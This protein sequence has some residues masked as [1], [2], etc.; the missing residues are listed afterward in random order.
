MPS[1][2]WHQ[3]IK[4]TLKRFQNVRKKKYLKSKRV[5]A[6]DIELKRLELAFWPKQLLEATKTPA[7]LEQAKHHGFLVSG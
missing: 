2:S 5:L 6:E 3:S 4:C 1:L 7:P